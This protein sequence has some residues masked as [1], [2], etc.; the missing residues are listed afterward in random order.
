MVKR[1]NSSRKPVDKHE[2]F[3]R[4]CTPRLNKALKAIGLLANQAGAAYAPTEPEVAQ[5]FTALRKKVNETEK[6]YT[7]GSSKD[8]GFSF[9][10]K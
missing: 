3:I 7:G 8:S 5:M 10:K 1:T 4:V 9:S 6:V 2:S